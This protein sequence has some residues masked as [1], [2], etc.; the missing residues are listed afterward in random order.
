[1][2]SRESLF[3]QED[4][5]EVV[6]ELI[7]SWCFHYFPPAILIQYGLVSSLGLERRDHDD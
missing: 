4:Y 2:D 7:T 5:E 3:S 1:M 6:N